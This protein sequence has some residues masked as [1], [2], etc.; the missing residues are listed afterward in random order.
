[1]ISDHSVHS[2]SLTGQKLPRLEQIQGPGAP[3]ELLLLGSETVVGRSNQATICIDSSL[4][5]RRHALFKKN[6][7]ELRLIDLESANGVYVNGVRAH[8]A[9][10]CEGDAIQIGDVVLVFRE[11]S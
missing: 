8:S 9:I 4:L 1:M 6:G 2:P 5:S 7:P 11:G 3:R 10:L